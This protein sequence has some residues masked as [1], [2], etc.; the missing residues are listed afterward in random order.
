MRVHLASRT[1]KVADFPN[2]NNVMELTDKTMIREGCKY[3]LYL[4]LS[5]FVNDNIM[6]T[7]AVVSDSFDNSM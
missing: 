3:C 2:Y 4:A 1:V 5:G 7:E 6:L